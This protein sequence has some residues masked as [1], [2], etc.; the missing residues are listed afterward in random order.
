[1]YMGHDGAYARTWPY[2]KGKSCLVCG[3]PL[4]WKLDP[5]TTVETLITKLK[6]DDKTYVFSVC[7]CLFSDRF[8]HAQDV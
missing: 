1:M 8:V 7:R 6:E 2:E 3:S 4:V 5:S